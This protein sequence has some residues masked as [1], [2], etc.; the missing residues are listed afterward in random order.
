MI[1]THMPKGLTSSA[2]VTVNAPIAKA[3]DA[4][5]NPALIKQYMMGAD[6]VSDWKPG[7]AIVWKGEYEGKKFEDKGTILKLEP[8]KVLQYTHYSPLTGKP[9]VPDNYH[10]V[11]IELTPKDAA[12]TVSLSQDNNPDEESREHTSK[13]W[14]GML[15]TLKG[16]LEK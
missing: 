16:L 15:D 14:Q 2:S 12:T 4:L 5:V 11:T 10:T 13:F 7:S 8:Q 9:D 3:W 1:G 6:V